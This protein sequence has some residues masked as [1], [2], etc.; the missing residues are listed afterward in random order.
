VR[1]DTDHNYVESRIR[2][3]VQAKEPLMYAQTLG[4]SPYYRVASAVL[5]SYEMII[6]SQDPRISV[7]KIGG[8]L[9]PLAIFR[10]YEDSHKHFSVN[11]RE[12]YDALLPML[13]S[14]LILE[15]LAG[16]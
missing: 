7:A 8:G 12:V 14:A 2:A 6:S 10:I 5:G 13:E 9:S 16:I 3:Y 1:D 4:A 15:D 11:E